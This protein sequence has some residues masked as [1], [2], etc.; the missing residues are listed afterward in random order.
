MYAVLYSGSSGNCAYIRINDDVLLIDAG[1][2]CKKIKEGL[3]QHHITL[4]QVKGI[5]LTHEH[6][7]HVAGLKQLVDRHHIMIYTSKATYEAIT[8]KYQPLEQDHIYWLTEQT[9]QL[10]ESKWHISKFP[11]S[12][13]VVDGCFYTVEHN[14]IK[15]VYLTDTGY[16][17]QKLYEDI[18]N[19]QGYV[20]E[21]NHEPDLVLQSKYPWHIRQR[22]L[23]DKGHLSNQDCVQ[24][25]EQI[26][27]S[28]TQSITLAHISE[29]NNRVDLAY[30]RVLA[31]LERLQRPD[32]VL[33][34]AHKNNIEQLPI[35]LVKE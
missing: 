14:D 18:T 12:H 34:V 32:I 10:F 9:L 35:T 33:T 29:E 5:L 22:I 16:V 30:N 8:P 21:S 28:K 31:L 20:I 19:A 7:D 17:S 24:V 23:S 11:I 3:L 4:D 6:A 25:L 13:D 27:G 1:V 26:I 15:L 2:S